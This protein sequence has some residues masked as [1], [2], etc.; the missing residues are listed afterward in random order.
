MAR[1]HATSQPVASLKAGVCS[2]V[3]ASFRELGLGLAPAGE[4][5]LDDLALGAGTDEL[6]ARGVDVVEP[7]GVGCLGA[8]QLAERCLEVTAAA[9]R[10]PIGERQ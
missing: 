7:A 6:A 5:A 8:G 9:L 3:V 2:S 10:E 4:V 1:R